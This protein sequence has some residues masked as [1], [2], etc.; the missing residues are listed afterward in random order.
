MAYITQTP[1]EKEILSLGFTRM[2]NPHWI[3][4]PHF[5]NGELVLMIGETFDH[6]LVYNISSARSGATMF[7]GRDTEQLIA[8][9][10][11]MASCG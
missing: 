10:K 6:T 5:S 9:I 11:L 2:G 3:D 8:Y 4:V 1:I 7:C